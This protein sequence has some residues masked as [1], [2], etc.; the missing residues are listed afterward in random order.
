M[1][2]ASGL[3]GLLD[4]AHA[5]TAAGTTTAG[6]LLAAGL[7]LFV[8]GFRAYRVA[9]ALIAFCV[10]GLA[11]QHW[12]IRLTTS[13][14]MAAAIGA[15]L[16]GAA[17]L[18]WPGTLIIIAMGTVGLLLSTTFA[19]GEPDTVLV[20]C[21]V[22][23]A[24]GV[25]FPAVFYAWLPA[26]VVPPVA[27][28]LFTLG[29]WGLFGVSH[30]DHVLYKVPAAWLL[31]AGLLTLGGWVMENARLGRQLAAGT[32]KGPKLQETQRR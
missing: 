9:A 23:T 4:V 16:A 12:H 32:K 20:I 26:L 3:K 8:L 5:V 11:V 2:L 13:R 25:I 30:A 15:L 31:V 28:A 7:L 27:A 1:A 29:G 17:G 22:A 19:H 21:T 24:A 6:A 14:E 10:G 18:A